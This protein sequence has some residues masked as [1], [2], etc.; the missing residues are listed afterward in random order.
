MAKSPGHIFKQPKSPYYWIGY[1]VDGKRVREST[2]TEDY[3]KAQLMLAE[4]I[5]AGKVPD[6]RYINVLLDG[7]ID[8]Y[9]HNH[10]KGIKWCETVVEAHLRKAFGKMKIDD[11]SKQSIKGYIDSRRKLKR[12]NATIN[13]EISLLRRAFTLADLDFPKVPKLVENNVRKG[14]VTPEEYVRLLDK[15][16]DHI[17]P[18]VQFAYRTGC[19]RGEI[20]GLKWRNI[21][22]AATTVRLEPGETKSGQ[23]RTIPL[24]S[25]LVRM[26]E[27]MKRESEYV[28]TYRGSPI[29][30]I[31]TAWNNAR[32]AAKLPHLYFHD[33]RRTGVRNLVRA[34]VPEAVTMSISGHKTRAV[35]DRYNIV[36]EA[37]QKDA[38]VK[39]EASQTQL[40]RQAEGKLPGRM[41]SFM[42]STPDAEA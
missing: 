42:V 19:R 3:K 20:L 18:I 5:A 4:K 24:S 34:G 26:F 29:K 23:G 1:T 33:L 7:L 41:D 13:R 25:D 16:P 36:S 2:K 21:D 11:I 10:R 28:F 37:D 31:K 14:F 35:F 12:A 38:M 32:V 9:R 15:M 8:D 27:G 6:K 22:L 30:S 39:L 17:K 40:E